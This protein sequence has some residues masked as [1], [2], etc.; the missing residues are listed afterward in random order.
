[1]NKILT[2]CDFCQYHTNS[3]CMAKPNSVY[4][5]KATDEYYLYVRGVKQPPRKSLRPWE[6]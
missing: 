1:M 3:G 5:K 4:C 6:R 2:K